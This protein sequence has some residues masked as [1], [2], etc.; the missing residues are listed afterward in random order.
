MHKEYIF[1]FFSVS[2]HTNR[3]TTVV[4]CK[5]IGCSDIELHETVVAPCDEAAAVLL[6]IVP[7]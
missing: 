6:N 2:L 3:H 1:L 5:L 4:H 7:K